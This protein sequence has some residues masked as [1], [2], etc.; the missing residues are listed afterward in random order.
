M[1]FITKNELN[2]YSSLQNNLNNREIYYPQGKVVGGS[3]SINAMIY[4][5]GLKTDFDS[6][7]LAKIGHGI[8]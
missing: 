7:L 1:T 4:A 2:F 8:I 5:R 6:E 3:G